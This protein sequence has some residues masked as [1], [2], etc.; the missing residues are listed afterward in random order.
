MQISPLRIVSREDL[1]S[2]I[3]LTEYIE[4][5]ERAFKA[6]AEG[7]SFGT[8]MIHGDTPGD[9]EFHIKAGGLSLDGEKYYALKINASSFSN[10]SRYNLPN[11]MGAIILFDAEKGLPLAIVDSIEPTTKRTGAGTAVALKYLARPDSKVVTICGCGT[12]GR[13]QLE[14]IQQVCALQRVFAYDQ[15]TEITKKYAEEMNEKLPVSLEA[16]TDLEGACLKSDIV[17]TCTPSREPYLQQNFIKQGT[18]IAAIGADSPDK[19]EI[20]SNLLKGNKVVADI[21]E[22]CVKVGE[23]HH[24]IERGLIQPSDIHGEIGHI[25]TGK[26]PGRENNE[27][28][29]IYDAT[30][31]ALQDTASA[32]LAYKKAIE[33]GIGLEVSLF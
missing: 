23:I 19:Q 29:I 6:Y 20:D 32:V 21:L 7:D 2:L 1:T 26:L 9:I 3:E 13:I 30:G 18:T 24:G 14:S 33:K 11:I 10:W 31:T 22:Q 4:I 12:Q 16:V 8:D 5:V 15:D 27:E 28:I 25:I 17:V